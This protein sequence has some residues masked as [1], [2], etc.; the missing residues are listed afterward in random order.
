MTNNCGECTA[1]CRVFEIP[2]LNKAAGQWCEHCLIGKGCLIYEE[3]R[4]PKV[5]A[6]FECF[7]LLSQKRENPRERLA[8]EMRPDKSKVVLS[9]TTNENVIAATTMPGAPLAHLRPDIMVL[10]KHLNSNGMAV[11]VGQPRSTRRTLYDKDGSHE[12]NLT[13]PDDKGMQYNIA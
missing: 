8:P 2:A 11:V 3:A 10:I 7:W 6:D 13:E 5:C 4:R 9:P 1:C 12:V